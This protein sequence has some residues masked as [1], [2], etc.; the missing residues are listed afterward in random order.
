VPEL[1]RAAQESATRAI[2]RVRILRHIFL[3]RGSNEVPHQQTLLSDGRLRELRQRH[4]QRHF[5]RLG[6]T[7]ETRCGAQDQLG[8]AHQ[9]FRVQQAFSLPIPPQAAHQDAFLNVGQQR[10]SATSTLNTQPQTSA[11]PQ[12]LCA[13]FIE[14]F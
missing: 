13:T 11:L 10:R 6:A 4:L 9:V 1:N 7:E 14:A 3:V 2:A 8:A 12:I 5:R